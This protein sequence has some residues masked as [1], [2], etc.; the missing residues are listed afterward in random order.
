MIELGATLVIVGILVA[1]WAIWRVS[2]L[3]A[4]GTAYAMSPYVYPFVLG[5]ALVFIGCCLLVGQVWRY[6]L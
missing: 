2:S 1:L 6:F 4:E 3:D 5:M